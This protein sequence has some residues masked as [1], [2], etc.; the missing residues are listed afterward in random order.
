[1]N[2]VVN[3]VVN[4]VVIA[5]AGMLAARQS[6]TREALKIKTRGNQKWKYPMRQKILQLRG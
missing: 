2:V 3:V 6:F 1:M 5:V 4:I